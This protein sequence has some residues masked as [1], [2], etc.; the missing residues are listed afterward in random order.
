M[1]DIKT[2]N[3]KI[4]E[5]MKADSSAGNLLK[6]TLSINGKQVFIKTSTYNEYNNI[7]LYESYS[8]IIVCRLL[9]ELGIKNVV[10]YYP[11]K[12][13]LDNGTVTFGC[14]SYSFLKEN[15]TFIS[16]AKLHKIGKIDNY[17]FE[18]IQGYIQCIKDIKQ[19]LNIDYKMELDKIITVDW[20]ILNGDRHTGNFGFI[21]NYST[22]SWKIAPIFDNGNS[23]FSLKNIEEFEYDKSLDNFVSSKPFYYKHDLQLQMIGTNYKINKSVNKT[24]QYLDKLERLG[25][26]K[27]RINFIKQ[28]IL[29][30]LKELE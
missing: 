9:K 25:L 29:F 12:I 15:E 3:L 4:S 19:L 17:M 24:L 1:S 6:W 16:M 22:N 18:G 14:Y 21:Y 10:M 2:F 30:R 11:C 7:W 27:H 23:L 5:A 26:S 28:M 8:E 20:L 13:R